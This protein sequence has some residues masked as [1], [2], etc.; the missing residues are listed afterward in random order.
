MDNIGDENL[1]HSFTHVS[2]CESD[3]E[4]ISTPIITRKIGTALIKFPLKTE[5]SSDFLF[6]LKI[7]IFFINISSY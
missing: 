2:G 1:P 7:T 6:A 5:P 3:M 4:W